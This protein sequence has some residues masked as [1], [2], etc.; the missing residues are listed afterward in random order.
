[1][2]EQIPALNSL[3][4]RLKKYARNPNTPVLLGGPAF[5]NSDVSA[6]SLGASGISTDALQGIKLAS[7]LVDPL[8]RPAT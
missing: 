8:K 1:L 6:E 2:V 5:F 3:I 4:H 7:A